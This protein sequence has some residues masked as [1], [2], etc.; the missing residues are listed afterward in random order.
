M[1]FLRHLEFKSLIFVKLS[2]YP[3]TILHL[4]Y[5]KIKLIYLTKLRGLVNKLE[6]VWQMK[7]KYRVWLLI[8]TKKMGYKICF[9]TSISIKSIYLT[10]VSECFNKLERLS[11]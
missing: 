3:K 4:Y 6:S 8:C 5:T 11:N 9:L 7:L 1:V 10:N 2:N